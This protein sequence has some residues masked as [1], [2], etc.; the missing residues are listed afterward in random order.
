[1]DG[2]EPGAYD[3]EF[4]GSPLVR[5][6]DVQYAMYNGDAHILYLVAPDGTIY[7]WSTVIKIKKVA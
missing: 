1:M 4:V 7:N 3:V 6:I 5:R 2:F